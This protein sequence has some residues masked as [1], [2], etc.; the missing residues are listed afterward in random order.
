MGGLECR[1]AFQLL[2]DHLRQFT[3][4]EAE[5]I[6]TVPARTIR[7]IA[8]E[9]AEA[10]RVGST[11]R[12]QGRELPYRPAAAVIFRGGQGHTNT[13]HACA[14]VTLL[15]QLV[16]NLDVVG[17]AIGWP[18]RCLGYPGGGNFRFEPYPDEDGMLVPGRWFGRGLHPP[19]CRLPEIK[20]PIEEVGL[21]TVFPLLNQ[22]TT[23]GNLDSEEVWQ[24]LGLPYRIEAVINYGCN[25]IMSFAT[26]EGVLKNFQ[27]LPF[28]ASFDL[29]VTEFTESFADLVLPD[30]CYLEQL[31]LEGVVPIYNL[32]YGLHDWAWHLRQPVI[33]P[34]P[35]RR[36]CVGVLLEAARRLGI[37]KEFIT[38]V[39]QVFFID[40]PYQLDPD[41]DHSWA[42]ICDAHLK[43][44][45]GPERDLEWFKKHGGLRWPKKVEEV[46]WRPF[47]N[48]RVPVY[49]EMFLK[50]GWEI[51]QAVEPRGI[52]V[53]WEQYSPLPGWFPCPPHKEKSEEHDLYAFSY[54]DVIHTG[55]WTMQLPYIDEASRLNPYTYNIAMNADTAAGK[56]LKDGD[57]IWVESSRG[58]KIKGR[59]KGMQGIHPRCLGIAACS[60]HWSKGLPIARGKGSHFNVLLEPDQEH[61]DPMV[62]GIETSVRVKVYKG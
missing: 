2:K 59:L 1:P 50:L 31:T 51:R 52:S 49:Y 58:R 53:E 6:S 22:P 35:Q 25:S 54:R 44:Q 5:K 26:P 55:T 48:V 28:V 43:S 61:V 11:I 30:A 7:R 24:K 60:G 10:A 9:F 18:A 8:G 62:Q 46:Y 37:W 42:E 39:N 40:E 14:A 27:K 21:R 20:V 45:F 16:G 57:F 4:E 38:A 56:G 33:E 13:V 34:L 47:L 29:F 36:Q 19:S 15:N 17:G 41:Q 12:I 23:P 3:C 32:P